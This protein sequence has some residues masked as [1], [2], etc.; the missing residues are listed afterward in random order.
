MNSYDKKQKQMK[1]QGN[2]RKIINHD[3]KPTKRR[4]AI[5]VATIVFIFVLLSILAGPG[6]DFFLS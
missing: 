1:N 6:M 3:R 5:I 2:Y 4:E